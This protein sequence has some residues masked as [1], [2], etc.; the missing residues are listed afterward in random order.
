MMS[1]STSTWP[2]QNRPDPIPIVGTDTVSVM[3]LATSSVIISR[4]IP[5]APAFK[6]LGIFNELVARGD[7]SPLNSIASMQC[8]CLGSDADVAQHG[9]SYTG[10]RFHHL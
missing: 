4:T 5:N 9:D 6:R 7:V 1:W 10:D 8:C 2:S 3:T